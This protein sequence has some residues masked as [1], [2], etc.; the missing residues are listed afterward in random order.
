VTLAEPAGKRQGTDTRHDASRSNRPVRNHV[1]DVARALLQIGLGFRISDASLHPDGTRVAIASASSGWVHVYRPDDEPILEWR[2]KP[3]N[4]LNGV[5][6]VRFSPDGSRL[7]TAAGKS[8][9]AWTVDTGL[10]VF[11]FRHPGSLECIAYSR[12]SR[13]LASSDLHGVVRI[14]D[15]ANGRELVKWHV[16]SSVPNEMVNYVGAV[17][18][19]PDGRLL[20]TGSSDATARIWNVANGKLVRS[21]ATAEFIDKPSPDLWLEHVA[22]SPDGT[23]LATANRV[24]RVWDTQTGRGLHTISEAFSISAITFWPVGHQLATGSWRDDCLRTWD[25]DTGKA[26]SALQHPGPVY[27]ITF[28]RDGRRLAAS[29][30]GAVHIWLI[31]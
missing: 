18:F 4:F 27:A 6:S 30:K 31:P 2:V 12:D 23:Q 24:A 7:V 28:S 5:E 3:G 29:S 1:R 10:E 26:L 16:D 25:S 19:S 14:S 20:A 11:K 17:A 8:V 21:I 15:A 13:R 22:F 9:Q